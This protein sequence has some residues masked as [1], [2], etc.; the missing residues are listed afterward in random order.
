MRMRSASVSVGFSPVVPHGTRKW[1]PASICRRAEPA[2][3]PLVE[4]PDRVNGVTSAVPT[5]VQLV[6][7]LQAPSSGLRASGRWPGPS[8][9]GDFRPSTSCIVNQPR[10][11]WTHCAAERAARER[12]AIARRMRQRNRFG[13]SVETDRVHARNVAGAG[14]G[15]VDGP[16]VARALHRRASAAAP[17]PTARPSSSRDALRAARRRSLA[18]RRR[19]RPRG[20]RSP[21]TARRRSR[22]SARPRRRCPR[23][24]GLPQ[25]RLVRLPAG[26]A[27][28]PRSRRAARGPARWS[29]PRPASEKSIATSTAPRQRSS[30][31]GP[32]SR[33]RL[34]IDD[35]GDLAVVLA[36]QLADQL[37]HPSVTD[38]QNPAASPT[39]DRVRRHASKNAA[40]SRAIASGTSAS[41]MHERDVPARSRLRDQPQR[42]AVERVTARPKSVGSAR[43]FSPT[44]QTIAMSGSQ[45]TSAKFT[46]VADDV[47][48]PARDC[49][50]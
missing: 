25:R 46:Q 48:E 38:E 3:G 11:P 22:N 16:G 36:G 30:S 47:L 19:A 44:A 4:L 17:Y 8:G 20:R 23:R 5:P 41:R 10:L 15:H 37:A 14:R 21:R 1:M 31:A 28:R 50:R 26:G 43:R 18:A 45:L 49:P 12:A 24:D 39:S 7:H 42:N 9:P 34:R 32:E 2:H 40:C 6:R 33:R 27:D 35:A 13:R 29:A